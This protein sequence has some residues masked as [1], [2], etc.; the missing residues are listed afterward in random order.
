MWGWYVEERVV[1]LVLASASPRRKDLL[2]RI[3]VVPQVIDPADIDETEQPD[4]LP[5]HYAA[6][7]AQEKA[8][9]VR[10]RHA[11]AFILAAD[12]AVACGRRI[13]PKSEDMA[14]A[15]MCLQ[16]LSG[17]NHHVYGGICLITP[18]G[19]VVVKVV[20]TRVAFKRL[21]ALEIARYLQ[22]GEWDGKAGGYAIQGMAEIFV[23]QIVGSHSNIVGLALH[24]TY[25]LLQGN[26]YPVIANS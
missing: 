23:R 24:E 2:A 21:S 18:A 5:R 3:G 9:V 8:Q 12:T 1:N 15:E 14:T 10:A 11:D 19:K 20:D 13:L 17:R 25:G 26:G 16:L 4:E 22:S 7:M 6:R